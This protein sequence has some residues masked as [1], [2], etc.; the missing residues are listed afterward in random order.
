M[1]SKLS[2]GKTVPE[3][4]EDFLKYASEGV[5]NN[6]KFASLNEFL[7]NEYS[8]QFEFGYYLRNQ[9]FDVQF[10]R[11]VSAFNLN[12]KDFSKKEIDLVI[13]DTNGYKCAVEFK[14][15]LASQGET[16]DHM[17]EMLEDIKFVSALKENGFAEGFAIALTDDNKY[18]EQPKTT[19]GRKSLS[20]NKCMYE[21]F[22]RGK[23]Y[24]SS[25]K[26]IS[27]KGL[28]GNYKYYIF[29]A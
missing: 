23:T 29:E 21:Y 20:V 22:R 27:W 11:N 26:S 4:F 7:Y 1:S 2:N 5:C 24:I 25:P 14:Y 16:T 6:L 13:K 17:T 18:Y 8:L 12:K 9:G 28:V 19:K 3:M 10:E 15:P